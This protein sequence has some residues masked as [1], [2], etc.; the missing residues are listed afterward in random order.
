MSRDSLRVSTKQLGFPKINSELHTVQ[1]FTA[2]YVVSADRGKISNSQL[3]RE[4]IS[5]TSFT[6]RRKPKLEYK[7]SVLTIS[8]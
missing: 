7:C 4:E 6:C 8:I 2:H 5:Y 3:N 1:T